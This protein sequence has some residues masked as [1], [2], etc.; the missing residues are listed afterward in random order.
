M[1]YYEVIEISKQ[2]GQVILEEVI[3]VSEVYKESLLV[4]NRI[5][6]NSETLISFQ[7]TN[8]K[9]YIFREND[10]VLLS[11][12]ELASDNVI[13]TNILTEILSDYLTE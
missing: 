9:Y 6:R 7:N 8:V 12:E 4:Y 3:H 10:R 11:S 13:E 1:V 2:N 5:K